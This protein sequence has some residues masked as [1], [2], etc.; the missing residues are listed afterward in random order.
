MPT[1]QPDST[2]AEPAPRLRPVLH[3]LSC[4]ERVPCPVH[5]RLGPYNPAE[6]LRN[7]DVI[8][9]CCGR[10]WRPNELPEAVA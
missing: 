8:A 7:G 3:P 5:G 1:T 10:T 6:R 4:G 2:T 9:H